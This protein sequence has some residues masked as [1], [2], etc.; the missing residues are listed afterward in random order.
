[1]SLPCPSDNTITFNQVLC[2]SISTRKADGHKNHIVCIQ[3]RHSSWFRYCCS[4]TEVFKASGVILRAYNSEREDRGRCW[5]ASTCTQA[6]HL[7]IWRKQTV[8]WVKP[9][10]GYWCSEVIRTL[11]FWIAKYVKLCDSKHCCIAGSTELRQANLQM[12]ASFS[13]GLQ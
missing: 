12:A 11:L 3:A 8:H 4:T 1:M 6:T 10:Q 5:H 9:S 7:H 2:I 13:I